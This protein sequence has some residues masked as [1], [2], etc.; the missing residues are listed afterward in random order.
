M[1]NEA[2]ETIDD[3]G[4]GLRLWLIGQLIQMVLIGGLTT[5][6]VWF[7]G[8][9]SPLALGVIAALAEFVP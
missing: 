4:A 5:I 8:L 7:V 3:I 1:R 2:N 9:P 6:A